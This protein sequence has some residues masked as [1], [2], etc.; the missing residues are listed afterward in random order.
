MV[1]RKVFI[2]CMIQIPP[3]HGEADRERRKIDVQLPSNPEAGIIQVHQFNLVFKRA[4]LSLLPPWYR[5]DKMKTRITGWAYLKVEPNQRVSQGILRVN[6][7]T[8][9]KITRLDVREAIFVLDENAAMTL[10]AEAPFARR[11]GRGDP[12]GWIG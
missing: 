7:P 9:P 4:K 8:V 1:A 6:A 12:I 2:K 10:L 3:G 11:P 5:E